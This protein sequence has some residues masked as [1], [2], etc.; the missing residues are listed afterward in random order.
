MRAPWETTSPFPNRQA[1]IYFHRH[2]KDIFQKAIINLTT[3][4]VELLE[5]LPDAQG[6]VSSLWT[7][8]RSSAYPVQV[9]YDEFEKIERLC[10]THPA[11][12]KEVQKLKLLPG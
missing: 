2:I 1:R 12:L 4:D 3:G 8:S 7:A 11:V 9:D 10:N 5:S 6:R